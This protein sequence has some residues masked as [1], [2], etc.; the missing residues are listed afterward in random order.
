MAIDYSV[1]AIS[2]GT[3]LELSKAA[4]ASAEKAALREAY[5]IVDRRD[6]GIC[7]ATGI[8]TKPFAIDPTMR[9]EHHHIKPRSTHPEL[10][11]EPSNITTVTARIHKL[12]TKSTLLIEGWNAN[13]RLIFHWNRRHVPAGKEPFR[14]RS[15]RRSQNKHLEDM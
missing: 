9:R 1:L 5:A 13:K 14:L 7:Q 2:K 12:I 4:K 10:I 8:A 11:D 3:P 15:K 6:K